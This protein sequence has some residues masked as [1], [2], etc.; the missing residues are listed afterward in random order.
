[1]C[2]LVAG[3]AGKNVPQ[4]IKYKTLMLPPPPLFYLLYPLPRYLLTV[5]PYELYFSDT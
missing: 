4:I 2:V 5:I 3:D 1:M